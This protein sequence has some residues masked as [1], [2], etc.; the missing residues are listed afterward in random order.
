[1]TLFCVL[2][3]FLLTS[4]SL[5][6]IDRRGEFSFRNFFTRRALRLFPLYYLAVGF[7][8][9]LQLLDAV[10]IPSLSYT[11]ALFYSYNFVPRSS[12]SGL[13][14]SFHTLATEEHF[15]VLFAALFAAASRSGRSRTVRVLVLG[16][17]ALFLAAYLRPLFAGFQLTHFIGRWTPV[18]MQPIVVGC[19]GGL[20]YSRT[21]SRPEFFRK[22]RMSQS[23]TYAGL[24]LLFLGLYLTQLYTYSLVSL[25]I[26]FLALIAALTLNPASSLSRVLSN[27][28]LVYPGTVSYGLYVWQSVLVGTGPAWRYITSP[29]TAALLVFVASI[30]S[31]ELFEKKLLLLKGNFR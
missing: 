4:I 19:L 29:L 16:F 15:Y 1:M 2:S 7:L 8:A 20:I 6:E 5:A 3:G 12:Y 30:V 13:L 14:G 26:A 27:R 25:S 10:H 24:L 31:Y 17:S 21:L 18:A 22:V 28:P 9:L 23:S 11:Y